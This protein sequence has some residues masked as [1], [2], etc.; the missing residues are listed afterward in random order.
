MHVVVGDKSKKHDYAAAF[1]MFDEDGKGTIS[2]EELKVML[3]RLQ[4]ITQTADRYH[5]AA[6]KLKCIRFPRANALTIPSY[7]LSSCSQIPLLL[8]MFDKR[9]KGYITMDDFVA[10]AEAGQ[11]V[12][13]EDAGHFVEDVSVLHTLLYPPFM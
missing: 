12:D 4:L 9:K 3:V 2:A 13:D 6:W 10:F 1:N 11:A 8:S 7:H 5:V